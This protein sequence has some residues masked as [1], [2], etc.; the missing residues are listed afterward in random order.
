M[1]PLPEVRA[2]A[3]QLNALT[4]GLDL[5]QGL[6]VLSDVATALIPSVVGV[7]LTVV[8]DGDPFT[9]TSTSDDMRVLDAAQYLDGGPCVEASAPQSGVVNVDDVLDEERWQLYRH[10]AGAHGVRASLSLPLGGAGGRTPGAINLY[11]ADPGAF[12]G[13]EQLLAE[14]F[15]TP[16]DEFVTNADLSFMTRDAARRLPEDLEA[17]AKLDRA[18]GMLVG[19]LGWPADEAR[20]R[21][22]SAAGQARTPLDQVADLIVALGDTEPS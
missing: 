4:E 14:V 15:Q 2:A 16:A 11:A 22:R 18:T 7:S 12:H 8:V 10:A 3:E 19:L 1:Q 17:K 6:G 9:V 21:L 13:K 20:E 5:L